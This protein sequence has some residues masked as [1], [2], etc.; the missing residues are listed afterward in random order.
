[1]QWLKIN[2]FK[3]FSYHQSGM[4]DHNSSYGVFDYTI[5]FIEKTNKVFTF[6]DAS[7]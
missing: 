3:L 1:M 5:Y 4:F 2:L 7:I 6:T